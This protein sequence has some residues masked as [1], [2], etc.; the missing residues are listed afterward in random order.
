MYYVANDEWSSDERAND[1]GTIYGGITNDET[2]I[3]T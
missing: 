3:G 2:N 1:R